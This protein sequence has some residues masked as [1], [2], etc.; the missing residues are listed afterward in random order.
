VRRQVQVE[1]RAA[2]G[3]EPPSG[4]QS[5]YVREKQRCVGVRKGSHGIVEMKLLCFR[6]LSS[7]FKRV[8]RGFPGYA[9]LCTYL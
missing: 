6:W 2:K 7:F 3:K 5:K 9:F 8:Q 1:K 4:G